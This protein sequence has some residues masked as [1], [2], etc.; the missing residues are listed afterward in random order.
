MDCR[1]WP[2]RRLKRLVDKHESSGRYVGAAPNLT[3]NCGSLPELGTSDKVPISDNPWHTV[4][5]DI[6]INPKE[7]V[8]KMYIVELSIIEPFEPTDY[9]GLQI[10]RSLP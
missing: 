5:C 2:I 10:S 3:D 1:T 9:H 7:K 8:L 4:P 6:Q